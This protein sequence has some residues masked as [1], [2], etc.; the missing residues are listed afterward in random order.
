MEELLSLSIKLLRCSLPIKLLMVRSKIILTIIEGICEYP[1]PIVE[2]F[3]GILTNNPFFRSFQS[4]SNFGQVEVKTLQRPSFS[5]LF[6]G[7]VRILHVTAVFHTIR[8][9]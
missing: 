5:F 7:A 3:F 4:R 2:Q 8:G 6:Q 9:G 1:L